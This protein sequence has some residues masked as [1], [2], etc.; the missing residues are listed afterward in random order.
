MEETEEK[1][2]KLNDDDLGNGRDT[3]T[4]MA[5]LYCQLDWLC[6]HL[7]GMALWCLWWSFW[8]GLS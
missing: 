2:E 4:P 8:E 5:N 6:S 7:A 3:D 1:A